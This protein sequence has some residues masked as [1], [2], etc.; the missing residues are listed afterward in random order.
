MSIVSLT[1]STLLGATPDTLQ[2]TGAIISTGGTSL[3][4]GSYSLLTQKS[5]LTSLLAPALALSSI[6]WSGGVATAT[7][8]ATIPGRSVGDTFVTTVANAA[9][10]GYN[11]TVTA[12]MTGTTTFTYPLSANPG[13]ETAAG[14]YT[15]PGQV[16]LS[17]A[18]TDFFAQG[19]SKAVYVLELGPSDSSAGPTALGTFISANP[20]V[21]YAY[22]VPKDWD[23][24]ANFL[25]LVAQFKTDTSKTY[26]F[27]T[28]T[29]GTYSAYAGIK[30]VQAWVEA[31]GVSI[32]EFDAAEA[33]QAFLAY[34]PSST[35]QLTPFAY[36]YLND[37]TP[38]PQLGNSAL[39]AT[40]TTANVNYVA[41]AAEGGF[42]SQAMVSAGTMM[43]GND[44]SWW[45]AI[46]NL[47]INAQRTAA[48]VVIQ[49]SNN[50]VAPIWY[51]QGG[52]NTL[53][54]AEYQLLV[55][56]VAYA[57]SQ[58]SVTRTTL[59]QQTFVNNL[60]NGVYVGQNVIN[61]VPYLTYITQN[62]TQYAADTYGGL[63]IAFWAPQL[64]RHITIA[65]LVS[66]QTV[67]G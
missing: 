51:S 66:N 64:F 4:S 41:T 2:G 26:F 44:A 52:I 22:L 56:S 23:G 8:A 36:K 45:Y 16:M 5:D 9:P 61:A 19:A 15:P 46:D 18:V 33:F 25:S 31:P 65:V 57:L 10:A 48:A 28:T 37:A 34:A 38:N 47:A 40:L 17:L 13:T 7:A 49:G 39:L 24:A 43:D 21:F 3:A 6:T 12:T 29:T 53:Q 27:T 60:S 11:G 50:P 30:S 42:P 58:G 67:A 63:T 20:Q 55:N 1:V 32:T 62:P 35:N 14:T 59:D 54:D